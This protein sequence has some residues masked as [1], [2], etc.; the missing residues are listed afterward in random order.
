MKQKTIL[1]IEDNALNMKLVQAILSPCGHKSLAAE[2]AES[3]LRMAREQR[4]DIVLM[5]IQL[6][7][8]DGL[9][10]TRIIKADPDL[11][12]VPVIALTSYAMKEDRQ[13]SFAA[14]CDGYISKPLHPKHFLEKLSAFGVG[15]AKDQ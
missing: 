13:K 9:E 10:A 6:P 4:P 3:G 14:G 7:A 8:M 11:K 15:E 12:D 1:V 2:D 5:D